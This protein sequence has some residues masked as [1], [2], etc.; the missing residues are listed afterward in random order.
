MGATKY[1]H[2]L[3]KVPWIKKGWETLFLSKEFDCEK[4]KKRF[5][6]DSKIIIF[7]GTRINWRIDL[8]S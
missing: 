4:E 5:N 3:V 1:L 2:N 6:K 7:F 8:M